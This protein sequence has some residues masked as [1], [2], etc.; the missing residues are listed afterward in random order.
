MASVLTNI[1]LTNLFAETSSSDRTALWGLSL[2][3]RS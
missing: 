3:R 2:C 1:L